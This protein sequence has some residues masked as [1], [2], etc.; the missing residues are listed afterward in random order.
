MDYLV[1]RNVRFELLTNASTYDDKWWNRLNKHLTKD[2]T[3]VFTICGS[4]QEL[5]ERYRVGQDL[6]TMLRH[7][8]SFKM[9]NPN[10]N[11]C[12]QHILFKYNQ[13]DFEKNMRPIIRRFSK[14]MLIKTP[15]YLERFHVCHRPD[16]ICPPGNDELIY[17]A[18]VRNAMVRR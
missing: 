5:H 8:E 11:D 10:R 7:A 16:G 17:R 9:G 18:L 12:I 14:H 3:V 15:P 4:T 13:L 2:D 1:G 6:Q